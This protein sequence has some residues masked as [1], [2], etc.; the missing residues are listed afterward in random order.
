VTWLPWSLCKTSGSAL[1]NASSDA[2]RVPSSI[3][4]YRQR[5]TGRL[6]PSIPTTRSLRVTDDHYR[7]ATDA[8]YST[9]QNP[10][11]SVHAW[12]RHKP[13]QNRGCNS[14][15]PYLP[16]FT[17][18]CKSMRSVKVGTTGFEPATF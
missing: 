16:E 10:V 13:Q 14:I 11:Q 6:N 15:P 9:L 5:C 8:A 18:P 1:D 4:L 12:D 7:R 3:V 2:R 17:S